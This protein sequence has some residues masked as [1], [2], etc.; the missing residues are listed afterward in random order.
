MRIVSDSCFSFPFSNLLCQT[1]TLHVHTT[2]MHATDFTT[3]IHFTLLIW[4][5][6]NFLAPDTMCE[7]SSVG[8]SPWYFKCVPQIESAGWK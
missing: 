6:G 7:E 2:H 5:Q 8:S 1:H 4:L 3:H